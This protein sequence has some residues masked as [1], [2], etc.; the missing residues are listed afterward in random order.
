MKGS[1]RWLVFA[2]VLL[3]VATSALAQ[4]FHGGLRGA[5]REA[6]G[7]V[8]GAAVSLVNEGTS[9]SR[10]TQTNH[11]GEYAFVNVDPGDYTLKV[12][13][14]RATAPTLANLSRRITVTDDGATLPALTISESGYLPIPHKNKYG[15]DYPPAPDDGGVYPAVRK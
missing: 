4:T 5:V 3:A 13:H 12:F 9:A 15:R 1:S 11:L 2:L 10:S 14:E 7:V 6:G 8:P